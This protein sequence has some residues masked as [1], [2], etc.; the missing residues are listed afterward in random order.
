MAPTHRA[1]LASMVLLGIVLGSACGQADPEQSSADEAR[2]T[3]ALLGEPV[4]SNHPPA[5]VPSNATA[6]DSL[7]S[8]DFTTYFMPDGV[9]QTDVLSWYE[10]YMPAGEDFRGLAWLEELPAGGIFTGPDQYWCS[11]PAE[12]LDVSFGQNEPDDGG[13]AFITIAVQSVSDGA[14]G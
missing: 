12:S 11:G 13:Q 4:L 3:S 6:D 5:V 1:G 14:C 9:G 8:S 2:P 10:R 7:S